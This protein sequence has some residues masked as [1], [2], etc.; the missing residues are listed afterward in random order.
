MKVGKFRDRIGQKFGRLS[1]VR[2]ADDKA[3]LVWWLCRC[4]CGSMTE[5]R[6]SSLGK[7]TRSCGCL[8]R[9]VAA[10]GIRK[11]RKTPTHGHTRQ[12]A[13]SAEYRAWSAMKIRCYNANFSDFADYGGRGICVCDR[14]INS[15]ENFL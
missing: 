2:R 14:W 6:A 4:D 9:E 12:R 7:N 13:P 10:E 15:F 5:V 1:V 8:Q 3:R 11:R